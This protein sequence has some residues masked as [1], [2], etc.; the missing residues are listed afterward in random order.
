MSYVPTLSSCALAQYKTLIQRTDHPPDSYIMSDTN[1]KQPANGIRSPFALIKE[2]TKS[3]MFV[4][5]FTVRNARKF[6]QGNIAM[7]HVSDINLV[8]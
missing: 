5:S 4:S 3:V 1:S 8:V 7:R 2:Q 6:P